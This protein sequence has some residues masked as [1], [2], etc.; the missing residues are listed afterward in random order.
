MTSLHEKGYALPNASE[1]ARERLELLEA[2]H[3]PTSLRRAAALGVGPGWRCLE[4]GAG[5]GSFARWLAARVGPTGRVVAADLDV[6]LLGDAEGVELWQM[7]LVDEELPR[8]EFD[9]VHCR[10]LL[11]H[12]PERDELLA[13]LAAAVRPGGVLLVEEDDIH[14]VTATATG[15]YAEAW[16]VFLAIM[17]AAGVDGE[18]ARDLPGRLDAFG[19]EGVGAELDGQLFRGGSPAARLWSLT[20]EQV[21]RR[22]A[23]FGFPTEPIDAG[24][25]LLEDPALWFHGPVRVIAW[26][27]QP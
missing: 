21:R 2:F 20:W 22:I 8:A 12:V 6:G 18:W 3:D 16:R 10:L 7:N 1:G 27:R 19:L 11:L 17:N 25:E 9:L 26:G 13:R 5:R 14:P 23:D 4:A 24:Q 15:D